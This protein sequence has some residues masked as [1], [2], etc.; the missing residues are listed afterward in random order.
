MEFE[1]AASSL[2]NDLANATKNKDHDTYELALGLLKDEL[3]DEQTMEDILA[4]LEV[5]DT[6]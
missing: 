1:R 4:R 6:K 3:A 2:Y 5:Q